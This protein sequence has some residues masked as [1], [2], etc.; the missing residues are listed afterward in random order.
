MDEEILAHHEMG[1]VKILCSK[2]C[3]CVTLRFSNLFWKFSWQNIS[4]LKNYV[5]YLLTPEGFVENQLDKEHTVLAMQGHVMM[6]L[7]NR[8]ELL[9]LQALLEKA[10]IEYTRRQLKTHFFEQA[11]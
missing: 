4:S 8:T 5:E 6:A 2:R 10:Q 9:A 7:V 1:T 3:S 11:S